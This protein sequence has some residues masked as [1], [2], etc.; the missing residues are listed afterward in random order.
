MNTALPIHPTLLHPLTGQPL[1]AI[2]LRRNGNP[3]WPIMGGDG[4]GDD[5]NDAAGD[6]GGDG[7]DSGDGDAGKGDDDGKTDGADA[8]GDAGKKAL[9]TMKAERKAARDSAAS[10][11][12]R[13]D[14]LQAKLDGKEAEHEAAVQKAANDKAAIDKA[15]GRILR[16]EIKAAAKG[17]LADPADAYKFLDLDKFEVSEDGEVDDDAISDA[18][19]DLISKKPYLAVQDGKRFQGGAD[20]GTRKESGKSVDEQIADAEKAGDIQTVI[21]LKQRRSAELQAKS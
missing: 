14:A 3:I 12:A 13:A 21:A 17:V 7:K 9:D 2:G 18:L 10:E 11:K 16:S 4:T 1:Q 19:E 20:G 6:S 8:L 5:A 15:N